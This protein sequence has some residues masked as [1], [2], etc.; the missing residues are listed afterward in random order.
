MLAGAWWTWGLLAGTGLLLAVAF[1]PLFEAFHRTFFT[2]DTFILD[3]ADTLIRCFPAQFWAM[4]GGLLVGGSLGLAALAGLVGWWI[5]TQGRP[6]TPRSACSPWWLW[7]AR[8]S[9][10]AACLWMLWMVLVPA[11]RIASMAWWPQVPVTITRLDGAGADYTFHFSGRPHRGLA[12]WAVDPWSAEAAA[13]ALA[14]IRVQAMATV[15]DIDPDDAVLWSGFAPGDLWRRL[16]ATVPPL[17][18]AGVWW[19]RIPS[20]IRGPVPPD[21]SW[22]PSRARWLAAAATVLAVLVTGSSAATWVE[23]GVASLFLIVL[24]WW[25]MAGPDPV[26]STTA[27]ER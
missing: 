23:A 19:K 13:P 21:P 17:I 16:A 12:I 5:A 6:S 11:A 15:N 26:T 14:T 9:L 24:A 27:S 25:W 20:P 4:S 10:A 22:R 3:W 1:N 2:G 7:T 18:V 8:I